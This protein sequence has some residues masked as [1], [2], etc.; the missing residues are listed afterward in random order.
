MVYTGDLSQYDEDFT[1]PEIIP[2]R[3]FLGMPNLN[4]L[5]YMNFADGGAPPPPLNGLAVD[6]IMLH[7][8]AIGDV[9]LTLMSSD[10]VTVYDTQVIHQV[11][12]EPATIVLLAFGGLLLR[13]RKR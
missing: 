2:F 8:E 9:T 12:P 7:C 3:D 4:D 1:E 5:S 6:D 13:R 10:F 11:I